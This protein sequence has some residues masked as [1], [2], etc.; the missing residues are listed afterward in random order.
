M[1]LTTP[2]VH[3]ERPVQLDLQAVGSAVRIAITLQDMGA[4][5]GVVESDR[6]ATI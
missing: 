2:L 4:G 6:I 5:V 3:V 1:A